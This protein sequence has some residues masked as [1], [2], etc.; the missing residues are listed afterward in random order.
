MKVAI[1]ESGAGYAAYLMDRLDEKYARFGGAV[2]LNRKPSEYLRDNF[3]FVMDPSERSID[4]QCGE[5]VRFAP[6]TNIG[7][8]QQ[9]LFCTLPLGPDPVFSQDVD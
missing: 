8:Q 5:I 3:W 9:V 7:C 1:F 4:A 2:N 6:L